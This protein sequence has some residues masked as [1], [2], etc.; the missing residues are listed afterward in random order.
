MTNDMPDIRTIL[1]RANIEESIK[2][3]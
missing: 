1:P 3:I 2:T